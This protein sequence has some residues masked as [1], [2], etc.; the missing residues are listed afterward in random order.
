MR[1]FMHVRNAGATLFATTAA[2]MIGAISGATAQEIA[3]VQTCVRGEETRI[4]EAVAPGEVGAACDLRYIRNGGAN[5]SVPFHANNQ[6][7]WCTNK[8]AE[9]AANLAREGFTCSAG[10]LG[11]RAATT[12]PSAPEVAPEIATEPDRVALA[13]APAPEPAPVQP[14][15]V[16]APPV[17]AP[18]VEAAPVE[19]ADAAPAPIADPAPVAAPEPE[20]EIASGAPVRLTAEA[21]APAS[22]PRPVAAPSSATAGRLVGATPDAPVRPALAQPAP[23]AASPAPRPAPAPVAASAPVVVSATAA[24]SAAQ[25]AALAPRPAESLIRGVLAAQAAAWNEGDLNGFM[26]GYWNS[27]ELSFVAGV[28]VTKGWAA[29]L[30]RYQT[31]YGGQGDLGRLSFH[32]LDIKMLGDEAAIVIGRYALDKSGALSSGAFTLVMRRFEGR[33]RIVHDHTA[34]DPPAVAQ[35]AN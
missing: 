20:P 24:P 17:E 9:F 32:N 13:P 4:L 14:A 6:A 12:E 7:S 35:A 22:A 15:Q 34:E 30:K 16:E 23:A 8:A 29:T 27:P 21:Q 11:L 1:N 19:I 18:Q 5:V 25:P 3:A 26:A 31:R 10:P 28:D 2:S 33:W